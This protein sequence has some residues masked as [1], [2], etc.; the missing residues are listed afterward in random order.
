LSQDSYI[1]T[2]EKMAK[3]L[4]RSDDHKMIGGVCSGLAGYFDLDVSLVRLLFVALALVTA[5]FPMLFFYIIAWIII[6]Q[7]PGGTEE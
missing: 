2:E 1:F 3:R 7:S 5:L 6:P 4:Y